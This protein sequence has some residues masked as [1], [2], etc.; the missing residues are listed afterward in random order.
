MAKLV[1]VATDGFR[2][3]VTLPDGRELNLGSVSVLKLVATLVRGV[4]RCRK[5][6]DAFL[7]NGQTIISVDL[8]ELEVLLKPK[9][10]RWACHDDLFIPIVFRQPFRGAGMTQETTQAE[11]ITQQIAEIEEHIKLL[12]QTAREH[13]AGSLSE[14]QVKGAIDSLSKMVT[15]L[16]KDPGGQSSNRYFYAAMSDLAR[17]LNAFESEPTIASETDIAGLQMVTASMLESVLGR[18]AA[19]ID[20]DL[21]EELFLHIQNE[22]KLYQDRMVIVRNLLNR[23]AQGSYN[24]AAAER[25]WLHFINTE[26]VPKYMREFRIKEPDDKYIPAALRKSLADRLEKHEKGRMDFGDYDHLK[27]AGELPPA[28]KKYNE[29]HGKGEGKK[30]DDDKGGDK[31]KKDLPPWLQ[32]GKDK[33]AGELP[34]ALKKYNEEHGKGESKDDG[35]Q[36]GKEAGELPPALKKYNEEHGKGEGKKDD[37]KGDGKDKKSLPP[38]LQKGK[39]KDAAGPEGDP[40][41]QE[42]PYTSKDLSDNSTYYKLAAKDVPIINEA[43]ANSVMTKIESTLGVV[44]ASTK[45]NTHLAKGDLD[46]IS[47]MLSRLITGA[48]LADP[49]L[50][51]A[52]KEL[53]VMTDKI[54]SHFS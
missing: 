26:V 17:M 6:L 18:T 30:D 2:D 1:T 54:N 16:G 20:E 43:L 7:K 51:A 12:E 34:P 52:L 45:I 21:A 13:A 10:S 37:D 3:Y 4:N 19:G 31:D 23:M 28:L 32:K 27:T 25:L 42:N 53:S 38:W 15:E 22:G 11:A 44:E 47:S 48:D 5:A 46:R 36:Q 49:S 41:K 40:A 24:A 50:C 9:R 8:E 33:D 35:Q 29:E 39:D 14:E